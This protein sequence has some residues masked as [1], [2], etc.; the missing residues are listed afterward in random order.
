MKENLNSFIIKN[1]FRAGDLI[2]PREL[3]HQD[4]ELSQN[5]DGLDF[6]WL[7]QKHE[8][9]WRLGIALML[10]QHMAECKTN[11]ADT[12]AQLIAFLR[13]DEWRFALR[14]CPYNKVDV[15]IKNL[16]IIQSAMEE[17]CIGLNS[18]KAGMETAVTH[19]RRGNIAYEREQSK[20]TAQLLN[21][22]ALY[23]SY[24]DVCWRIRDYCKL[25]KSKAYS[26]AIVRLTSRNS[27]AH[28]FFKDLRN[29][30][31]HYHIQAPGLTTT[32]GDKQSSEINLDSADMLYSGFD[33]KPSSRAFLQA[34][35]RV[36]ILEGA[37]SIVRDVT[38][39]VEF[40]KRLIERKMPSE[41]FAYR[42]YLAERR[43]LNHLR[44]SMTDINS[45]FGLKSTLLDRLSSEEFANE[46]LSTQLPD[47]DLR[48]LILSHA[49][50]YGNLPKN[51][52]EKINLEIDKLISK[53][54]RYPTGGE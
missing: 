15:A 2:N 9:L 48:A 1:R 24:I 33:W 3:T 7:T 25:K 49:N 10:G 11:Q 17:A 28:A 39:V 18:A 16:G 47:N 14:F 46:L 30:M 20:A 54:P 27:G 36:N 13:D 37:S 22:S 40:H 51:A 42:Y 23:A 52:L 35:E 26:S 50:R 21:F 31:L 29:F 53:R 44:K 43:K 5:F 19:G 4:Y 8:E 41:M 34:Q 6:L 12:F 38:N 45:F 32:Y